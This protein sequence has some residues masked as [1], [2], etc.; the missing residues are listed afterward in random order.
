MDKKA[1]GAFEYILLLAGVLLIVILVIVI[2]R[3]GILSQANQQIRENVNVFRGLTNCTGPIY[4]VTTDTQQVTCGNV[5]YN[6]T[7]NLTG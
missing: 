6:V 5:V 1:Q 7:E 2:L 4:N 3:S